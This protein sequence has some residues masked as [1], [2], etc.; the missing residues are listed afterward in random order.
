M[1]VKFYWA[2]LLLLLSPSLWA[3]SNTSQA[4]VEIIRGLNKQLLEQHAE[5]VR[6]PASRV[7]TGSSITTTG[8]TP[9]RALP[10]AVFAQ[11]AEK[12]E[13]LFKTNPEMAAHLV[14]PEPV[15]R[16]LSRSSPARAR[17]LEQ[18]TQIKG[19]FEHLIEDSAN[20]TTHRD[21]FHLKTSKERVNLHFAEVPALETGDSLQ[22]D[23]LRL[24]NE[25]LA[26][27]AEK[28]NVGLPADLMNDTTTGPLCSTTGPQ[29]VLAVLV[30]F[31]DFPIDASTLTEDKIKGIYLGNAHAPTSQASPDRN[32]SD[33]WQQLSDGQTW[34]DP[35]RVEVRG[36]VLL[37]SN[38]NLDA[39]GKKY[40]NYEG[41]RAEVIKK[42][43]P[44]VDFK[45]FN[46][47][48]IIQPNNNACGWSG[49]A[50]TSCERFYNYPDGTFYMSTAWHKSLKMRSR[51]Y[52]FQLAAHEQ[53]HNLG[54]H[55]ASSRKF[56]NLEPIGPI[57]AGTVRE[58]NDRL[59]AMGAWSSG[60]YSAHDAALRLKWL[61]P[62]VN[63]QTVE[64][65]GTY[66]IQNYEGRPAGLKALRIRRGT[67]NDAW[68][69]V[70]SRKKV[71]PYSSSHNSTVFTGVLVRYQDYLTGSRTNAIDFKTDTTT[72]SD[73]ALQLGQTWKD[74]YSNLSL[75]V[76]GLDT[77]SA[78]LTVNYEA[79]PCVR[80][81]TTITM[82]SP[83]TLVRGQYT[84]TGF[85]VRNNDSAGC[86]PSTFATKTTYS[87][88][89]NWTID[90]SPP[91][92][93]LEP[94]K[95]FTVSVGISVPPDA[96]LG[97][98][99]LGVGVSSA[100]SKGVNKQFA[101]T[102]IEAS[103]PGQGGQ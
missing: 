94:G 77:T 80:G 30:S 102:V 10:E 75:T 88:P 44:E 91:Q 28:T 85:V 103:P 12:L 32:L 47:L 87:I 7:G 15:V 68:L 29:G 51:V 83:V 36:P 62:E 9:S 50:G 72:F 82:S 70:E 92:F 74:P 27:T 13:E 76:S 67:G 58:Y 45:R 33:Y 78:T 40:C 65:S 6:G 53:G 23:G 71:A 31:P 22:V 2:G 25:V 3:Q 20:L 14:L 34:I 81:N 79:L 100:T 43:D 99:A 66:V 38:Y 59:S 69:W 5:M 57:G 84:Q 61:A 16:D 41:I 86:A 48:V 54:L 21:I 42:I 52:G 18:Y 49:L 17:H 73:G 46:R 60:F 1:R 95:V 24:N 101:A 98:Y 96:E 56:E 39:R 89:P 26:L 19:T 35:A 63:Y 93:T 55:H 64:M 97:T 4:D 90:L 37:S 11:R 8:A